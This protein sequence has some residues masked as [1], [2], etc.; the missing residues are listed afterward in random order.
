MSVRIGIVGCVSA[1][2]STLLNAITIEQL[3]ET[4]KKRTTMLPLA[5]LETL[6]KDMP[7]RCDFESILD[8]NSASNEAILNGDQELTLENCRPIYHRVPRM[9]DVANLA[10][11]MQM[12][13]FDIPGL[14]DAKTAEIYFS[15]LDHELPFLDVVLLV[16]D[17]E[18]SFNTEAPVK[19]LERIAEHARMHP[20]KQLTVCVIANKCDSMVPANDGSNNVE[21]AQHEYED[22][23]ESFQQALKTVHAKLGSF[24]NVSS[25]VLRMSAEFSYLYRTLQ[26]NEATSEGFQFDDPSEGKLLNKLGVDQF[27]KQW[28]RWDEPKKQAELKDFLAKT[29]TEEALK[30]SGWTAFRAYLNEAINTNRQCQVAKSVMDY[31]LSMRVPALTTYTELPTIAAQYNEHGSV[32]MAIDS[33]LMAHQLAEQGIRMEVPT[34]LP[35]PL[36]TPSD[37]SSDLGSYV[38]SHFAA[39]LVKLWSEEGQRVD[40]DCESA[41]A[42]L[43]TM[44]QAFDHLASTLHAPFE[45]VVQQL[46]ILVADIEA[47]LSV[48][49]ASL[50]R[51]DETYMGDAAAPAVEEA[52]APA[53]EEAAVPCNASGAPGNRMHYITPRLSALIAKLQENGYNE[54]EVLVPEVHAKI[55]QHTCSRDEHG[56]SMTEDHPIG[57]Y[58]RQM[59]TQLHQLPIDVWLKL[60]KDYLRKMAALPPPTQFDLPFLVFRTTLDRELNWHTRVDS[61]AHSEAFKLQLK[62]VNAYGLADLSRSWFGDLQQVDM[63]K[64]SRT[65]MQRTV[66]LYALVEELVAEKRAS[67]RS[68]SK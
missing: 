22:L 13:F 38:A 57:S 34:P 43:D 67:R 45:P 8:I 47:Q 28:H 65:A 62:C 39:G 10:D 35:T 58:C 12:D 27:G 42:K 5:Y 20:Q 23:N 16:V 36:P 15:Y 56:V 49:Y 51:T 53:V 19:I 52:A 33:A 32:A 37:H 4:K 60:C 26:R 3:S 64:L 31:R 29:H 24:D 68:S 17:I 66:S 30:L 44:K 7:E 2:K 14:D 9:Y 61:E 11:G 59:R 54:F 6:G 21:F 63:S 55:L 1:G 18:N 50:L 41:A 48:W 46:R 25:K 40:V